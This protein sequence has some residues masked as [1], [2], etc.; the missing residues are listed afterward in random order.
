MTTIVESKRRER[1]QSRFCWRVAESL[2]DAVRV[3]AEAC[4]LSVG[5]WLASLAEVELGLRVPDEPR[6]RRASR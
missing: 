3:E 4:G 1:G 2:L 6:R 5:D